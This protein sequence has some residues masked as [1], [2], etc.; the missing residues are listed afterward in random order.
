MLN[1][2][3][4]VN[5]NPDV[6]ARRKFAISLIIGF[7]CIAIF[8]ALV[9]RLHAWKPLL[10]WVGV[11]GCAVGLVL[12]VLPQIARPFYVVWY[13]IACCIGIVV[14]NVLFM[15]F[16]YLVVTPLGLLRRAFNPRAFSKGFNKSRATYWEDAQKVL[17]PKR[18]YRQF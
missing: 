11:P 2:F 8:F 17:D 15:A 5:W 16:Y 1:P 13:G 18:Y 4:E 10:L 6:P 7:P 9:T 12:W 3:A 14:G